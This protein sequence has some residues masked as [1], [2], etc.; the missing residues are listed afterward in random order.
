MRRI[1]SE[2]LSRRF[3]RKNWSIL[4]FHKHCRRFHL[5]APLTSGKRT[6]GTRHCDS[7]NSSIGFVRKVEYHLTDK[8]EKETLC[9][10]MF[11]LLPNP[12]AVPYHGQPYSRHWS[13]NRDLSHLVC[14][15]TKP[16]TRRTR[17]LGSTIIRKVKCEVWQAYQ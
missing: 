2:N 10:K 16:S 12:V 1:D 3:Q 4:H 9:S 7:R 13:N 8:K 5:T 15:A 14:S 6:A 11:K 17:V